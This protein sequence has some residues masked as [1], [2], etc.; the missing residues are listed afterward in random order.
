[1]HS[2]LNAKSMK[3]RSKLKIIVTFFKVLKVLA[4][5][6]IAF[7]LFFFIHS[8]FNPE[9]YRK[10]TVN[11]SGIFVST[12]NP[13]APKTK[14]EFNALQQ[15]YHHW[16]LLTNPSKLLKLTPIVIYFILSIFILSYCIQLIKNLN[17]PTFFK[18]GVLY[19]KKMRS[20]FIAILTINL[21]FSFYW[22]TMEMKEY[23]VRLDTIIDVAKTLSIGYNFNFTIYIS[24][25]IY[26]I[27]CYFLELVFNEGDR[28][29]EENE[30]TV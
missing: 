16:N 20:C 22:H 21:L 11:K 26:I 4:F 6:S 7:L 15:N 12:D 5:V 13:D 18:T 1:M 14:E 2:Y 17:Y 30:L 25:F 3:N 28:L 10:V 27:I 9:P 24:L 8:S 19:M 23:D 29:R